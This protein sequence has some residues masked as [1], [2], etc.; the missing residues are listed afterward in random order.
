MDGPGYGTDTSEI[1]TNLGEE[2]WK[3]GT[4]LSLE[5]AAAY[6]SPRGAQAALDGLGCPHAY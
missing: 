1:R 6:A 4:A 5:E 2:A 3:E